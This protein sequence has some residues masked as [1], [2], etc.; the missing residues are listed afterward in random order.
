MIKALVLLWVV[1]LN[2]LSL[3]AGYGSGVNEDR[4]LRPS[5][6][7]FIRP[8]ANYKT[9]WNFSAVTEDI[10][11]TQVSVQV[12][13]TCKPFRKIEDVFWH[14]I[15]DNFRVGPFNSIWQ[16]RNGRNFCGWFH[17]YL[18]S[19][20]GYR[21]K[22]H[23][24][25]GCLGEENLSVDEDFRGGRLSTIRE[26]QHNFW[27]AVVI[28]KQFCPNHCDIGFDL[29]LADIFCDPNG[30]VGGLYGPAAFDKRVSD[31]PNTE[32]SNDSS[33]RGEDQKPLRIG[34]HVLLSGQVFLGALILY[35]GINSFFY[36]LINQGRI[37]TD[38]GALYFVGGIALMAIGIV[39]GAFGLPHFYALI[40][41]Y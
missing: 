35:A 13:H 11:V 17:S 16:V 19:Y 3:N 1:H 18:P 5:E 8:F 33:Q 38:T 15:E 25:M 2:F 9:E 22:S 29:G 30:I 21:V 23:F 26:F 10:L 36:A 20:G 32:R 6:P 40:E 37:K 34:R 24:L 39:F 41:T 7:S 12:D 14:W 27:L 4:H 28:N 31:K